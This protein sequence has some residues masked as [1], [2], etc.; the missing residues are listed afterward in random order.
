M[1]K[2]TFSGERE[3]FH[4]SAGFFSVSVSDS[5]FLSFFFLWYLS[6]NN[7]KLLTPY[8]S[9]RVNQTKERTTHL[10]VVVSFFSSC[11]VT[12]STSLMIYYYFFTGLRRLDR[13]VVF[14][15]LQ[16]LLFAVGCLTWWNFKG[17]QWGNVLE[18]GGIPEFI[19]LLLMSSVLF[20]HNSIFY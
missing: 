4:A 13:L 2:K 7:V 17:N 9:I 11:I 12:L 5:F 1:Y 15:T 8:F 6:S 18:F 20:L 3:V 14:L 19:T 16:W 10:F